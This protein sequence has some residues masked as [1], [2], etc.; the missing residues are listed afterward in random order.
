M[1]AGALARHPTKGMVPAMPDENE[2]PDSDV[3]EFSDEPKT[4]PIKVGGKKY[5]LKEFTGEGLGSWMS[6]VADK[7]KNQKSGVTVD[8]KMYQ[9][10][11]IGLCLFDES[12]KP[13]PK[14]FIYKWPSSTQN[15]IFAKCQE[16]NGLTEESRD[17]LKKN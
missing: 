10:T 2:A 16:M 5:T 3:L 4:I 8:G 1:R 6:S 7:I 9:A 12:D 14:E 15:G 13:V 17:K 11:L